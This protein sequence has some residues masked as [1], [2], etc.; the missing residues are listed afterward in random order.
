MGPG[1]RSVRPFSFRS[2]III[3]GFKRTR[4]DYNVIGVYDVVDGDNVIMEEK[5][6]SKNV[7]L[8]N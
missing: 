6:S 7:L 5:I 2:A 8:G 3:N 1:G 4:G